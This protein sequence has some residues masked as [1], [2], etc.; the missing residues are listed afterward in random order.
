MVYS[1][2]YFSCGIIITFLPSQKL[3]NLDMER[4]AIAFID[5]WHH[6][7]YFKRHNEESQ[8]QPLY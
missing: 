4:R 1:D 8:P 7:Y 3:I 2:Q 6:R 5:R